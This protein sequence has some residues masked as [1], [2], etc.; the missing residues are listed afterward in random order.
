MG[1]SAIALILLVSCK[2]SDVPAAAHPLS[3]APPDVSAVEAPAPATDPAPAVSA[4]VLAQTEAKTPPV[5][6]LDALWAN[7]DWRG[8]IEHYGGADGSEG[9]QQA[10]Y[11]A[12]INEATSLLD[13]EKPKD[14]ARLLRQAVA[15]DTRTGEAEALLARA[16]RDIERA[17]ASLEV[18]PGDGWTWAYNYATYE[19]QVRNLANRPLRYVKAVV[20][21]Y[22]A[23]G[24]FITSDDS[25]IQYTTLLPGQVSPFKVMTRYNPAMHKAGVE[26]QEGLVGG[27]LPT[28]YE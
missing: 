7:G 6:S 4:P 13:A 15:M 9:E 22:T 16:E 10:V 25:Y 8:I 12:Y 26:F 2:P 27:T 20:T 17:G 1:F 19:G 18:L 23:D 3:S 14:A 28:I 24:T 21:Y 5:P 11:A